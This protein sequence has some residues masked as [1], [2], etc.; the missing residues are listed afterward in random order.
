MTL[1]DLLKERPMIE[2][3]FIFCL[4]KAPEEIP[5]YKALRSG[6]DIITEDGRFYLNL[7]RAMYDAGLRTFDEISILTFVSKSPA[8]Q[9]KY[10]KRGG[11]ATVEEIVSLL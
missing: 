11:Y 7:A 10:E 5:I 2:C 6:T 1:S 4:Y 9:A 3:N 8:I